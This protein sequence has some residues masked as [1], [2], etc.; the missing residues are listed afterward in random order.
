MDIYKSRIGANPHTYYTKD[1]HS[2]SIKL[3]S[4]KTAKL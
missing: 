4:I 3:I 1:I 2:A